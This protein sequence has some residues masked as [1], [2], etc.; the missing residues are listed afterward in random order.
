MNIK[1]PKEFLK[2]FMTLV[3]NYQNFDTFVR[4]LNLEIVGHQFL[5][6]GTPD[7]IRIGIVNHWFSVGPVLLWQR[8]LPKEMSLQKLEE[9]LRTKPEVIET[10]LNYQGMSFIFNLKDKGSG[11]CH[12]MKSPCSKNEN[13][14]WR[15]DRQMI[16]KYLHDW[17]GFNTNT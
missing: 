15:I 1:G 17:Q 12:W 13:K 3:V 6:T 10:N 4:N 14:V 9:R 7:L 16:L 2:I 5:L 11:P 8:D